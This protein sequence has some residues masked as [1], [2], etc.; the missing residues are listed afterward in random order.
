MKELANGQRNFVNPNLKILAAKL[1]ENVINGK[2][3][4]RAIVFVRTRVLS[5]AVAS[6][7][8]KC[9]DDDLMRLNARKF[10]G[11]Q[12]LEDQGGNI[13]CWC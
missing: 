6:W 11:S 3:G 2:H 8:C 10:T 9:G 5:E 12:A 13:F 1:R 4:A 7:L